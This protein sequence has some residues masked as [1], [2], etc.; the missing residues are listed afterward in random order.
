MNTRDPGVGSGI[1]VS[2]ITP[3]HN[4]ELCVREFHRRIKAALTGMGVSHEIIL[5]NDGSTDGTPQIIRELSQTDSSLVGVFLARNRGQ[6]TAIY[7]GIQHSRGRYVVIMDGDLQHPPEEVPLLVEKIREGYDLVKGMRQKRQESLVLRRVPSLVANYLMRA[8]SRCDIHDMGGLSCIK[9]EVARGLKLREGQ[10]RLIPALVY[11]QGGAV[12]EVPTS[13]PPRFAGKSHY[14]IG[15]SVDVLFDIVMLWFQNS[16]KQRPLY[17]FGRISL[18]LFLA[19]SLTMCWLL[20]EKIFLDVH[21]GTRPPFL[22]A[23]LFYLASLGFMSTGLIL[24]MLTNT[25]DAVSGAMPFKVREIVRQQ[26]EV[27]DSLPTDI[28][29]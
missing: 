20:Y 4:E 11:S 12:C 25:L 9:G 27:Q 5:V 7:A 24:E 15:R 22:G 29:G 23:V 10:H 18:L 2:I 19:A 17:L 13:A 6:C 26:P 8:T 28:G 3:M 14:G 1:E 21:M 16:F